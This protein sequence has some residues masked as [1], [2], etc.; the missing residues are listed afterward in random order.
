M[1]IYTSDT[2]NTVRER[3]KVGIADYGVVSGDETLTTSGLGSCVGIA[4]YDNASGVAGLAHAMLPYANGDSKEAKYVDTVV[5]ALLQSMVDRG[6]NPRNVR[7]KLAGGS[8]MFEFSSTDGSIGDRNVAA[9]R[10]VL[11]RERI[12]I[13]AENVGG[14]H[15]RSLELVASTGDLRVRSANAG[16][17]TI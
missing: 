16:R 4:L 12:S 17:T 2:T 6:A 3:T 1:K 11:G 10:E 5:P 15:G 14:D 8:T 9:A 13:V 7:A